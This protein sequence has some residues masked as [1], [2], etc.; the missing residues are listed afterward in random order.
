M[1]AKLLIV[2]VALTAQTL[3]FPIAQDPATE[4]AAGAGVCSL[5]PHDPASWGPSGATDFMQN[6]FST[7]GTT[8]WLT[9][10]D[11]GTTTTD[12][13]NSPL[14][15]KALGGSTCVVPDVV[16]ENF[17]PPVLRLIRLAATNAHDFFTMAHEKL[18]DVT[19][20]DILSIDQIIADFAPDQAAGSSINPVGVVSA[21]VFVASGIAGVAGVAAAA[22]GTAAG[23]AAIGAAAGPIGAILGLIGGALFLETSLDPLSQPVDMTD[24]WRTVV[25]DQLGGTFTKA[26]DL[27][28]KLNSK[29]FGGDADLDLSAVLQ[30]TGTTSDGLDP[31]AQIFSSGAFLEDLDE[32]PLDD[33]LAAGYARIKQNLVAGLMRAQNFYVF[34]NTQLAEADCT[35]TGSRFINNECMIISKRV[36]SPGGTKPVAAEI[37]LKLDD[38][39]AGYNIDPVEMYQNAVDCNSNQLDTSVIFGEGLPKCFWSLPILRVDGPSVCALIPE[40]LYSAQGYSAGVALTRSKCQ[41]IF[42][43]EAASVAY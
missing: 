23:A 13:F 34:I 22:A 42:D 38:P 30:S 1:A 20:S 35:D 19:I 31:I 2:L 36:D 17:T 3:A 16:C 11:D 37:L 25:S 43:P 8:D 18:Q 5:D 32:S 15:C 12:G 6:W 39:N 27:I 24:E 33:A 9:A 41:D 7:N 28:E 29:L 40:D 21:G 10:M 26:A 14:N 4:P